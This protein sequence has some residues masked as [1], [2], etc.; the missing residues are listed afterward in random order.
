[1][2]DPKP[3]VAATRP[4]SFRRHDVEI[5][6][7][8]A[9]LRDPGYPDVT[10]KDVLA[11]LEEENAYY[12]A[13]M[14]PRKPL[15]DAL[16]AEMRGRIKEDESTVPQKDGD[17]LYWTD[18]ETGGQY[19]RWWR[20]PVGG[21]ADALILDEPALAEGKEYFRVGA[22]SIS[23]DG[24]LMAYSTDFDGSERYTIRFKDLGGGG[25]LPDA[26]AG[27][28]GKWGDV[29]IEGTIGNIVFTSDG[30]AILYGL[31]DEHW[32]T[33]TI[34]LHRLG[35][36]ASEDLVV[37][38]EPEP[39]FSVGVELTGDRKWIVLTASDH[40]TS[41]IRLLPAHDP[42]GDAILVSP[43]ATGR[44]YDVDVHG[45]TLFVH[46]NDTHSNWRLATAPLSS[47]GEWTERI[48]ASDHFYM[49]GVACFAGFFVVEG[50]EQG[51]DQI[52]LHRYDPAIAPVRIVFPEA[53]Y[54]AGLDDNPEYDVTKLRLGYQSMVTRGRSTTMTSRPARSRRSRCR[55]YR[56]ATTDR[57]TPP[58][59]SRSRRATG[60]GCRSRSS[61]RRTSRA[62][63]RAGS[64]SMPMAPTASRCRRASRRAGCRS[65]TAAWPSP[66]RISAAATTWAS[67]GITTASSGSGRTRSTISSIARGG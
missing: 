46:T 34:K 21:G 38:H 57:D 41:E 2:T 40:A 20:K 32:R 50:R 65:S 31:T 64:T 12:E 1:M 19:P 42:L 6:D 58:S 10:D 27:A 24:R 67:N 33:R 22:L 29:S 15:A 18:Y 54:V 26:V 61:I 47:P 7:P 55:R 66:S 23:E 53:S 35:S 16:F 44:E 30:G 60:P 9:W 4:H 28:A 62:T 17:W 59:G 13:V 25:E 56:A 45:D 49:T 43:R 48:A 63:D 52:E 3:P 11:Y 39:G 51:L 8:W 14:A 37:Y 36:E 5:E